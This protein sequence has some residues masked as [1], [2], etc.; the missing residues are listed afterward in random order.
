MMELR[1]IT[2]TVVK[3]FDISFAKGF[4]AAGFEAS[5]KNDFTMTPPRVEVV[6]TPR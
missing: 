5:V 6:M 2:A 3:N 1:V 4:D